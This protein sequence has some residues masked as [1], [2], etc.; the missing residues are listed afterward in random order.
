MKRAQKK[1]ITSTRPRSGKTLRCYFLLLLL[2]SKPVLTPL[3]LLHR[4]ETYVD[5]RKKYRG[6]WGHSLEAFAGNYFV[7]GGKLESIGLVNDVFVSVQPRE[8]IEKK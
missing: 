5:D 6:K 4:T 3:Y 2:T 1:V 7:I 8:I